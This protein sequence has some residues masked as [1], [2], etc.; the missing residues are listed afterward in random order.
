MFFIGLNKLRLCASKYTWETILRR[1]IAWANW[2]FSRLSTRLYIIFINLHFYDFTSINHISVF[3][4]IF[5]IDISCPLIKFI[6]NSPFVLFHLSRFSLIP[7]NK[8]ISNFNLKSCMC[9]RVVCNM[10]GSVR[11]D[12]KRASDHLEPELTG[13]C[14]TLNVGAGN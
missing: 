7:S 5:W 12:Q 1:K 9:L 11:G 14:R 10:C 2:S 6:P 8:S 13:N 3:I 4:G